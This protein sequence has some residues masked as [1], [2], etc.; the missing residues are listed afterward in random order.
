MTE[1]VIA[2]WQKNSRETWHVRLDDFQS[3]RVIDCRA[4]YADVAGNKRPRCGGLTVSV[5]HLSQLAK[6]LGEALI[7]AKALGFLERCDE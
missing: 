6:A 7:A 5:L 3:H 4:W 2:E 1:T